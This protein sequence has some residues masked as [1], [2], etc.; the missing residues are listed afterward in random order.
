MASKIA[1]VIFTYQFLKRLVTPFNETRAYQLGIID[2]FTSETD[3]ENTILKLAGLEKSGTK[4]RG[5]PSEIT[6]QIDTIMRFYGDNALP[7]ILSGRTPVGFDAEDP[8]VIRQFKSLNRAAPIAIQMASQLINE[9]VKTNLDAGL[10]LELDR[11]E[12]IFS[13]NDALEGLSALIESRR[14]TYQNS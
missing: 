14:P 3:L 5:K 9:S 8:F 1:D 6:G 10:Q 11:L 13:T 7:E 12:K 4:F 2:E